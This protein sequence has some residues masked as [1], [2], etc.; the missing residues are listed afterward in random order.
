MTTAAGS[1]ARTAPLLLAGFTTAFGANGV[2]AVLGGA[3]HE[4]LGAALLGLG[5][6]LAVYDLAE[7]LLK[8]VFGRL[9]D[10]V[11][12][13][14]VIVG[15]LLAFAAVSLLGAVLAV[16][17]TVVAVR[18]GQGAAASAFSPASSA[19]VARLSGGKR[20]GGAFGRYGSWKSLG[21][22]LGPLLGGV[23]ASLGG[24]PLLLGALALV[25]AVAAAWVALALPAL[26]PLPRGRRS[27]VADL[28]RRRTSPSFVRPV[29]LLAA[30][31]GSTA[32]AAGFL[33]AVA[34]GLG[35]PLPAAT[36]AVTVLAIASAVMQPIAGRAADAGR[37]PYRAGATGGALLAA[38][39][40]ASVALLPS[41]LTVLV[42]ALAI[43][44]GVG[45]LTPLGFAA[46]AAA[47]PAE[48]LGSTMGD[49]E[50]GREL[51]DAGAPT[52]VGLL[53]APLGVPVGLGALA[54]LLAVAGLVGLPAR[55][56]EYTEPPAA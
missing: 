41:V 36:A 30:G 25:A 39:G 42:A 31:A 17:A 3:V 52:L 37:L 54:L 18:F 15:G 2:A 27:T 55:A 40:F 20:L 5:V 16:P 24:S 44:A 48:R 28:L 47:T 8:P 45:L 21:Y 49:A 32:T 4:D 12:P 51:G 23:L 34:R 43:G 53:A 29:A 10:R 50:I 19:A 35:L 22:A 7:V 46:L 14:P 6:A 38:A 9:T 1:R 11:G 33:P 56:G 26:P 13:K